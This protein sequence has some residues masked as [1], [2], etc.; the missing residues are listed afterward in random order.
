MRKGSETLSCCAKGAYEG[1]MHSKPAK[2]KPYITRIISPVS[3]YFIGSGDFHT[4][5]E[6]LITTIT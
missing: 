2:T 1:T 6:V 4:A 3:M 5:D